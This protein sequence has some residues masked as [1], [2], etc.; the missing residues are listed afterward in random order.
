MNYMTWIVSIEETLVRHIEWRFPFITVQK[1]IT[2]FGLET[3]I[4]QMN[5]C[6]ATERGELASKLRKI[7]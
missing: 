4:S 2:L 3:K 1:L 7:I 5:Y 6:P